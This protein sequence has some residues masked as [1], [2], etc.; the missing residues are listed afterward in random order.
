MKQPSVEVLFESLQP[1]MVGTFG[2][3]T[4]EER[5]LLDEAN[6]RLLGEP[7]I[8]IAVAHPVGGVLVQHTTGQLTEPTGLHKYGGNHLTPEFDL[9]KEA[10]EEALDLIVIAGPIA[11]QRRALG[12]EKWGPTKTRC[13][14]TAVRLFKKGLEALDMAEKVKE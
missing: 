1:F 5:A 7:A 8:P 2:G 11:N 3:K 12:K 4:D 14:D 10:R 9:I 6:K 13:M